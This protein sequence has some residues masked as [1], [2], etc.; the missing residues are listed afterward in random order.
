MAYSTGLATSGALRSRSRLRSTSSPTRRAV[1]L[2]ARGAR[3][4]RRDVERVF[5]SYRRSDAG[6]FAADLAARLDQELDA[7]VF[8]D[9]Q[10]ILPGE[11]WEAEITAALQR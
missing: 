3:G 11:Q 8:M 6:I 4:Y 1:D 9:L 5:L 2:H 10:S 7:D